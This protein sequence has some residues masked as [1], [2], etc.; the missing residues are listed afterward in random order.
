MIALL[1]KN[2]ELKIE[3]SCCGDPY[4]QPFPRKGKGVT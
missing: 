3:N 4:P 2:G 1:I